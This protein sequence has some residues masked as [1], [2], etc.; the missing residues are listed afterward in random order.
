MA[1]ITNNI[2]DCILEL[3]NN[4]VVGLPTETVYGLAARIDRPNALAKIFSIKERPFFDPLI[5][6]LSDSAELEKVTTEFNDEL[7]QRLATEF[8]PGSLTLILPKQDHINPLIT[9]GLDTVGIRIP[10]HSL[11]LELIKQ[12][13]SPLAAPS[14]NKFGKTSPSKASHVI[15]SFS[16]DNFLV[17]DGGDCEVGIESTVIR[18]VKLEENKYQI[19]ILRPGFITANLIQEKLFSSFELEF[20]TKTTNLSPGH[21]EHHYMPEIPLILVD[22][23]NSNFKNTLIDFATQSNIDLSSSHKIKLDDDPVLAARSLYQKLRDADKLNIKCILLQKPQ[24]RSETKNELW[25]G[26]WDRLLKA[27]SFV[28]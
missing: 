9:S 14:A 19:E 7:V 24:L 20:I 21:L 5:V 1:S 10:K 13:G 26:I 11:A 18:P 23:I 22:D 27:S 3:D 4:G 17:L 2:S 8:W 6:H 12:C 16:N 28:D 15:E 25:D